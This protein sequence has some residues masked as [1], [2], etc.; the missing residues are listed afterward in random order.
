MKSQLIFLTLALF[1]AVNVTVATPANW[2]NE[3]GQDYRLLYKLPAAIREVAVR[4]V[5][6]NEEMKKYLRFRP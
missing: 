5:W 4:D 1:L 3:N 2:F 6:S